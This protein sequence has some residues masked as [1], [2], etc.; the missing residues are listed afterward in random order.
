MSPSHSRLLF[1]LCAITFAGAIVAGGSSQHSMISTAV[2]QLASLP[3][4]GVDLWLCLAGR[5][6][7][8][9]WPIAILAAGLAVGAAQL[10]PLPIPLWRA[11]PGRAVV[12]GDIVAA[13][14]AIPAFLPASL[15]PG[16]T[17]RALIALLPGVAI[18]LG[19]AAL[20]NAY[21]RGLIWL[22]LG[23]GAL[24]AVVG[25]ALRRARWP[26]ST[27]SPTPVRPSA[28]SPTAITSPP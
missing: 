17:A 16:G 7:H 19:V 15:D 3:L 27:R 24:S 22:A 4:L 9:V 1:G 12:L 18:F 11:L 10:V 21:R 28:S 13:G 23:L 5:L 2:A 8:A 25:L 6:R 14:G 20:R 26:A